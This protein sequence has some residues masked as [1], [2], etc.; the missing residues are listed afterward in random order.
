MTDLSHLQ[1][2]KSHYD[3][4][5]KAITPVGPYPDVEQGYEEDWSKLS[6][7]NI[8]MPVVVEYEKTLEA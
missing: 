5:P 2:T 7:G 3:I 1:Y 6:P 4:N 8:D